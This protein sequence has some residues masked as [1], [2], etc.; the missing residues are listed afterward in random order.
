MLPESELIGMSKNAYAE[1][2]QEHRTQI[3]PKAD[4]RTIMVERVGNRIANVV[5][6]YMKENGHAKRIKDFEW[7]FY[8]IDDPAVNAWCMPG[9]KVVVYTGILPVTE[10]EEGL[11]VVMGHEIAHAI[12]R[13]GNERM[14]KGLLLQTGFSTLSVAMSQN[15]S[16]T[17]DLLLQSIGIGG[18]LGMLKFS[19]KH[20]LESDHLGIIFMAMA[21]YDPEVAI[22]FWKRMGSL[23]GEKPPELLSTHPPDEKR[24]ENIEEH[25]GQAKFFYQ[26]YKN[27]E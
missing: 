24:V 13:H 3:V 6:E 26:A 17:N 18:Q 4:K 7:E 15:P 27:P 22:D 5:D 20:E 8:L 23:G 16:A 12:A 25:M 1:F 21:G 19:R 11:A 14:S 9:G 10:N 2:L